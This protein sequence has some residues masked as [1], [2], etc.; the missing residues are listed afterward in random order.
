MKWH[1]DKLAPSSTGWFLIAVVV[2]TMQRLMLRLHVFVS[3]T[4]LV[5][6]LP[7]KGIAQDE[8]RSPEVETVTLSD[9]SI[10]VSGQ[11]AAI[12]RATYSARLQGAE[13]VSGHLQAEVNHRGVGFAALDWTDVNIPVEKL[14]WKHEA[15]ESDSPSDTRSQSNTIGMN[16]SVLFGTAPSQK[17]LVLIPR[18]G[19]LIGDWSA[20]G[21][22]VGDVILFEL[23]FP[24]A[25]ESVLELTLPVTHRLS[26]R[27]G[28]VGSS[29]VERD[30]NGETETRL[31]TLQ[32]S[33]KS[34]AM[35]DIRPVS[36]QSS[37]IDSTYEMDTIHVLRRDGVFLQADI[38]LDCANESFD[39]IDFQIPKQLQIESITNTGVQL[40]FERNSETPG[41]VTLP[42]SPRTGN[43]VSI[44]L[45]AFQSLSWGRRRLL[46]RIRIRNATEV[47]QVASVRVEAP[48][49]IA[50][51]QADGYLQTDLVGQEGTEIWKFSSI[52]RQSKIYVDAHRPDSSRAHE[53]EMVVDLRN[54]QPAMWI[55]HSA[56]TEVG[57]LFQ[58]HMNIPAGTDVVDVLPV[59]K[60]KAIAGWSVENQ[61]LTINYQEAIT[62]HQ[63]QTAL[64]SLLGSSITKSGGQSVLLPETSIDFP[65]MIT[66]FA[67]LPSGDSLDSL[68]DE[69]WNLAEHEPSETLAR[70]F[71]S[72]TGTSLSELP[73][74]GLVRER[75]TNKSP[76]LQLSSS[77]DESEQESF[78]TRQ[79]KPVKN[80]LK[81]APAHAA[82]D[83]WTVI[84]AGRAEEIVNHVQ[85]NFDRVV[86][87]DEFEIALPS[88]TRISS[89]TVDGRSTSILRD[90]DRIAFPRA[91]KTMAEIEL[92]YVTQRT[93][94]LFTQSHTI[95]LPQLSM[96]VLNC[97]W[98]IS[99]PDEFSVHQ[100]R[101]GSISSM[102]GQVEQFGRRIL[103]P[104]ART[105]HQ[106]WFDVFSAQSWREL[107]NQSDVSSTPE[108]RTRIS[109]PTLPEFASLTTWNENYRS[110]CA[111][112]MFL[113]CLMIGV[114]ARLFRI[115]GFRRAAI[116]WTIVLI[117]AIVLIPDVWSVL[118]G[119]LFSGTLVSLMLPR[120]LVRRRDFFTKN[121]P[122]IHASQLKTVPAAILVFAFA[123]SSQSTISAQQHPFLNGS[124]LPA[125]LIESSRYELKKEGSTTHI[126]A[127]YSVTL[128]SGVTDNERVLV[129]FP[130]QNVV[131]PPGA[132]CS[133]DGIPQQLIP[134]IDGKGVVVALPVDFESREPIRHRVEI[135]FYIRE[136]VLKS[137]EPL[138]AIPPVLDS[139]VTFNV[140][141]DF[142]VQRWG[143]TIQNDDS[144]TAVLGAVDKLSLT[145][146]TSS[147]KA[148]K[149]NPPRTMLTLS[150]LST[151]A[152][153][154][155][156]DI[157]GREVRISIPYNVSV[158]KVSGPGVTGWTLDRETKTPRIQL[159][160]NRSAASEL[161]PAMVDI[162]YEIPIPNSDNA[163]QIPPPP[164]LNPTD[165]YQ[166]GVSATP[167]FQVDMEG[168]TDAFVSLMP[169]TWDIADS[170]TRHQPTMI[171]EA[172]VAS[173]MTFSL[174][175]LS[176]KRKVSISESLTLHR[177]S[178]AWQADITIDVSVL[179]VFL[180]HFKID[181]GTK[182]ER[183]ELVGAADDALR[184]RAHKESLTLFIHDSHIG[185][186]TFRVH[187]T[188]P[189]TADLWRPV[190]TLTSLDADISDQEFTLRDATHWEVTAETNS[191]SIIKSAATVD[192]SDSETRTLGTYQM[193]SKPVRVRAVP[194]PELTTVESVTRLRQRNQQHREV[195][196][197]YHFD[198]SRAPVKQITYEIP[199][200]Y[201][202]V[203]VRPAFLQNSIVKENGHQRLTVRLS[204]R[205]SGETTMTL[206]AIVKEEPSTQRDDSESATISKMELPVVV[207]ARTLRQFLILD[208]ELQ[209]VTSSETGTRIS[210]EELP[211]WVPVAWR[212]EFDTQQQFG[213][214]LTGSSIEFQPARVES[215]EPAQ[216][217]FIETVLWTEQG[218]GIRG[219]S[220]F[221]IPP[222][223]TS[224]L[225]IRT[226]RNAN[227]DVS[228]VADES[229]QALVFVQDK[230]EVQILWP[231]ESTS[232]TFT[233]HWKSTASEAIELVVENQENIP[234]IIGVH[235][236]SNEQITNIE[237]TSTPLDVWFARWDGLLMTLEKTRSRI[238]VDSE[239]LR[240]VPICE[241]SIRTML[242]TDDGTIPAIQLSRINDRLSKWQKL[243]QEVVVASD[244]NQ[245]KTWLRPVGAAYLLQQDGSQVHWV[246][247]SS[248]GTPFQIETQHADLNLAKKL[249][250][251]VL[252]VA[253]GFI[254]FR[255]L[256]WIRQRIDDVATIPSW[257]LVGMGL[258]WWLFF[259]PSFVGLLLVLIGI[260]YEVTRLIRFLISYRTAP[261]K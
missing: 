229:G 139:S 103:G 252:M 20:H 158:R 248:L 182:I 102:D 60:S 48:L 16:D 3:V 28:I 104:L 96:D 165:T 228:A 117:C 153:S 151:I 150:P 204:G 185:S 39:K 36:E 11:H 220:Q 155:F 109:S 254:C 208:D 134:M 92:V 71:A 240:Q 97:T 106:T 105:E 235:A 2:T 79:T 147:V 215:S 4:L 241:Q 131:F 197:T 114:G 221:W 57:S 59:N 89:A 24:K 49:E 12:M 125:T 183:V 119:G 55:I 123:I 144:I 201:S 196:I 225:S 152:T 145:P 218:P 157:T 40:N 87:A 160:V 72:Q 163:I 62:P 67:I 205:S 245:T 35:I 115:K 90:G 136:H 260:A 80:P 255:I 44:R 231:A 180:H 154:R 107:F 253:V 192:S 217:G 142:P 118:I 232:T 202:A 38:Q 110:N 223:N 29:E 216:V 17:R 259:A 61:Q 247:R 100:V 73:L 213:F 45:Q 148:A 166:V 249:V 237:N 58:S 15:G 108:N 233:V 25:M 219:V 172:A 173:P 203:R 31:W 167:G 159:L 209:M 177:D 86:Q 261:S 146:G 77:S 10:E 33:K 116:L 206:S 19:T 56:S 234:Q 250:L 191:G 199:G 76:R 251:V 27:S 41:I 95:P 179:P 5:M 244:Q 161:E 98:Q 23:H 132:T 162:E 239:L 236:S 127:T 195:L 13:L 50:N 120:R 75:N 52:N 226:A 130:L 1:F 143:A 64:I 101:L 85:F 214:E 140:G 7:V 21:R 230:N 190:P 22:Q 93:H 32:L 256:P 238:S 135:D 78:L 69:T 129:Q 128:L 211:E 26:S 193:V 113:S 126:H 112:V 94:G 51:I 70:F 88:T 74:T 133:V 246:L 198:T 30:A 243:K 83:I 42:L 178:M 84:G 9:S 186:R 138:V 257:S 169:E 124:S 222:G 47:K 175:P 65:R 82:C 137:I 171:I 224:P 156:S 43:R 189:F 181:P 34:A 54:R 184:W 207:S 242:K 46:P 111:W 149:K 91:V 200:S 6:A 187:G 18:E 121:N 258:A 122:V 170:P 99:T 210:P 174:S 37:P 176:P 164:Y 227:W 194:P 14:R 81:L 68:D 53:L 8:P 188:K 66:V 168:N 212:A 63:T 141:T